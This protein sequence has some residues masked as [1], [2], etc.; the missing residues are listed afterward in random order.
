MTAV[1]PNENWFSETLGRARCQ[2]VQNVG[3]HDLTPD[4]R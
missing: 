1:N 4:R 2:V 3:V